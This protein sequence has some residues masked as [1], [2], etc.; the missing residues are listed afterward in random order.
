MSRL[1]VATAIVGV[2]VGALAGFLWWGV[3][4][5]RLQAE[6][7]DARAGAERLAGE[8]GEARAQNQRLQTRLQTTE[9]DLRNEKDVSSRLH[10][11]VSQ[12]KK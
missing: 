12:G 10:V 2:L 8:L 4:T 9:K 1:A 11:L 3:P 6:L 7:G 5:S